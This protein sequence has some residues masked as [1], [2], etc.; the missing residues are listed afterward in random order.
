MMIKSIFGI[1]FVWFHF[2]SSISFFKAKV[3][4]TC[5]GNSSH[6][7]HAGSNSSVFWMPSMWKLFYQETPGVC[8]WVGLVSCSQDGYSLVKEIISV[9]MFKRKDIINFW[10][11]ISPL[12][13]IFTSPSSS[14]WGTKSLAFKILHDHT[15]AHL[16]IYWFYFL[17]KIFTEHHVCSRYLVKGRQDTH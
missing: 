6:V 16:S 9:L 17:K 8:G 7:I 4:C 15:P 10:K 5:H 1:K 3:K 12:L 14:L 11:C 13:K 2:K